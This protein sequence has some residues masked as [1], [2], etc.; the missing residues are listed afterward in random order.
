MPRAI[1]EVQE[2]VLLLLELAVFIPAPALVRSAANMGARIDK[3][4]IDER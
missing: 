4:A 2:A 3:A 1:D